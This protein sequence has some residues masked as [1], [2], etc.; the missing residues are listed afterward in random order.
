MRVVFDVER[1]GPARVQTQLRSEEHTS[2]LQSHLHLGCRLL[3]EKKKGV[4]AANEAR[5]VIGSSDA[6]P[7][8][9]GRPESAAFGATLRTAVPPVADRPYPCRVYSLVNWLKG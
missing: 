4:A 5:A 3:L 1:D 6:L 8:D 7:A 9:M 2:E